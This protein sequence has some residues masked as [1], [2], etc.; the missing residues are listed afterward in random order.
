MNN[1]SRKI[2]RIAAVGIPFK[3][4][5]FGEDPGEY[6]ARIESQVEKMKRAGTTHLLINEAPCALPRILDPRNGYMQFFEYGYC[7]DQFVTVS[8]N[9]DIYYEKVK[10]LNRELML[11]HADLARRYGFRCY[12]M[13]LEPTFMQ[14]A[15]F[16]RYPHWRGPRVDN[17]D[18]SHRP[19][20]APCV[21]LPQ[22]QDYYR[23]MM[24]AML[25]LVPEIDEVHIPT[26]D[27]GGG[28]CYS[29]GLYAGSNGPRHCRNISPGQHVR[30]FATALLDGGREVNPDFRVVMTSGLSPKEKKELVIGAKEGIC[31]SAYGAF[32][33]QGGL[34]DYWA[35]MAVG[36]KIF[37]NA[38]LRQQ[39]RKWAYDD[40]L[41]RYKILDYNNVLIYAAY[42][43]LYYRYDDPRP[44]ETHR[45]ICDIIEMGAK[46]LIGGAPGGKYS[47]NG[48]VM[49]RAFE[50]GRENTDNLLH[51]I[52]T[53]WLGKDGPVDDIIEFWGITDAAS[54]SQ[55]MLAESG[56]AIWNQNWIMNM[57]LV[58]DESKLKA[59]DLAYFTRV[60]EVDEQKVVDKRGGVWGYLNYSQQDI[61]GYIQQ[62]ESST[63]PLYRKAIELIEKCRTAPGLSDNAIDCIDEQYNVIKV[64]YNAHNMVYLWLQAARHKLS[65]L[66]TPDGSM[67][68]TDIIAR[69]MTMTAPR[70]ANG[71][72]PVD[73]PICN[74]DEQDYCRIEL[75]KQHYNDTIVRVDVSDVPRR[76][77]PGISGLG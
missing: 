10:S 13:C 16:E 47:I 41:E 38:D 39:S 69:M 44:Y 35:T 36:P 68:F 55:P 73:E 66:H 17:P 54:S 2:D 61:D 50:Y 30:E 24:K 22:V 70:N 63:L 32:A 19:I 27:T 43:P 71:L 33:W 14:E 5:R 60:T 40:L 28:F 15:M 52:A 77:H 7:L 67:P 53:D 45:I 1:N 23:Q 12:I 4:Y 29:E 46:N 21:H 56:H 25:E 62:F 64:V 42:T 3:R 57:P 58:P 65:H 31:S 75:M 49:R 18:C 34:E 8:Y 37:N 76:K 11:A 6:F 9:R 74:A 26:N 20:Y 59:H 51:D 48:A 72:V